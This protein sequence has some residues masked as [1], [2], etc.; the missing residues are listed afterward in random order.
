MSFLFK[1][2][3]S[4]KSIVPY[5]VD[6]FFCACMR[7]SCTITC[8]VLLIFF[9]KLKPEF[10]ISNVS[11]NFENCRSTTFLESCLLKLLILWKKNLSVLFFTI[12]ARSFFKLIPNHQY[13]QFFG[14]VNTDKFFSKESCILKISILSKIALLGLSVVPFLPDSFLFNLYEVYLHYVSHKLENECQSTFC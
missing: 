10:Y 12:L 13:Q 5:L 9:I 4:P 11:N 14:Q 8:T 3:L 6:A 7:A 1:A 2:V